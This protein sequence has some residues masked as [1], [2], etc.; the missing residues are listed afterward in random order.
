M[1][2]KTMI[3]LTIYNKEKQVAIVYFEQY[4]LN[5]Y[6]SVDFV[7]TKNL[8]NRQWNRKECVDGYRVE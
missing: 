1:N 6:R 8:N 3:E 4:N 7:L 2:E 5:Q